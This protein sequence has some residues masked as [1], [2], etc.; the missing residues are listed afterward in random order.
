MDQ[1][2]FNSYILN[3]L[4]DHFIGTLGHVFKIGERRKCLSR[5][6]GAAPPP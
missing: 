5:Q 6:A 4:R 1:E 3:I 2:R